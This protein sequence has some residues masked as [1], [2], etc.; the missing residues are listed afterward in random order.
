[1]NSYSR[2]EQRATD[3]GNQPIAMGS[4]A[5]VGRTV[6]FVVWQESKEIERTL[7]REY[8]CMKNAQ[9]SNVNKLV[10]DPPK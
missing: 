5:L 4:H 7:K 2:H 8:I 10:C 9:F 3:K 6:A 1:M